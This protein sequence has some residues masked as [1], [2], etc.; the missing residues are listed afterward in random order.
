LLANVHSELYRYVIDTELQLTS[1]K[2]LKIQ[3][4]QSEKKFGVA[5]FV[6]VRAI[7]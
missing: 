4:G 2:I 7:C 1:K 3:N 6:I 5:Y